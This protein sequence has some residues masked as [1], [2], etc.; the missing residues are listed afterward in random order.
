MCKEKKLVIEIYISLGIYPV[1]VSFLPLTCWSNVPY[2]YFL[3][4][5]IFGVGGEGEWFFRTFGDRVFRNKPKQP[6]FLNRSRV[7]EKLA[8][9]TIERTK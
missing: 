9:R 5:G 6:L 7:L 2:T 1:I 4:V 8:L 3:P